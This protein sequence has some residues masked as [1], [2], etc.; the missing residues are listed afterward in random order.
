MTRTAVALTIN[1]TI[2]RKARDRRAAAELGE[3]VRRWRAGE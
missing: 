3:I 2:N 1:S